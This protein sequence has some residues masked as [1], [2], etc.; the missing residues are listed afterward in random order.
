MRA[1]LWSVGVGLILL[2]AVAAPEPAPA[3]Q[4][5]P[6]H[7]MK[8]KSSSMPVSGSSQFLMESMSRPNVFAPVTRPTFPSALSLPSLT[9]SL[10]SF[11]NLLLMRNIFGTSPMQVTP[12]PK[13]KKN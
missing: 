1:C 8:N 10:P 9:P 5:A 11:Q 6:S 3:Q 13:K 7:L 2:F 4:F 12:P